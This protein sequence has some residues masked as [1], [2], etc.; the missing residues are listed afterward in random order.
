[1]LLRIAGGRHATKRAQSLAYRQA[2]RNL[3]ARYDRPG[4]MGEPSN[5]ACG[6]AG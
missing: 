3:N 6:E 4:R 2:G 1:M 5:S